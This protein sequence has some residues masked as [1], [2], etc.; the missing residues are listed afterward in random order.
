MEDDILLSKMDVEEMWD[1]GPKE[2]IIFIF[3]K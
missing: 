3:K 1:C 2:S